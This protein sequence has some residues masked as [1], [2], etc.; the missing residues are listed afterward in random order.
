MSLTVGVQVPAADRV[1]LSS[2][3]RSASVR[4]GMAQRARIVLLAADG[5]GTAEIVRRVEVSKPTVIG[6]KRRYASEGIAGLDDRPKSGR[7]RTVDEVAIVL[8]TLEPPPS[9]LGVTHWSSRLLA[10][11]LAVSDFTIST[12]WK[13][14]GLQ[15]WRSETFK[16]STD[17]ELVAK[18]TDV[19]GLYLAPP[20]NA[21]VLSLDESGR[22]GAR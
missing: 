15:P 20:Q 18:V 3:T 11:E 19:V 8:A 6:W 21:V 12:T 13:R 7:P 9:G 17:P 2:W 5:V 4:A 10:K 16:F 1:V 22:A 14:W